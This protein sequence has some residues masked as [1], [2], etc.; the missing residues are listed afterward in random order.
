MILVKRVAGPKKSEKND[1]EFFV[2]NPDI[3]ELYVNYEEFECPQDIWRTINGVLPVVH[4]EE[5]EPDKV[6]K[7]R[8]SKDLEE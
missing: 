7:K 2:K 1:F 8:K 5:S 6:I 4:E 3:Y